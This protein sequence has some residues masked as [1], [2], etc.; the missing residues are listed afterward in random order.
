[1]KLTSAEASKLL[2]SLNAEK[3]MLLN[4]EEQS[5]VFIAATC[6][7]LEDACPEY[8]Y[9]DMQMQLY[10]LDKKIRILK[11]AINVFN[12]MCVLPV[13][14][15]TIDQ[16]LVYIP[17]LSAIKQKLERMSER[18]PKTRIRDGSG[19]DIIEYSYANY[20]VLDAELDYKNVSFELA[21][22]QNCLDLANSTIEFEVDI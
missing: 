9:S 21:R 12:V 8:S 22:L 13:Y 15:M 2:N 11:H 6:E 18:L 14:D 4:K 17:Q 10:D 7:N 16:A 20:D 3:K 19:S 1:M 5:C